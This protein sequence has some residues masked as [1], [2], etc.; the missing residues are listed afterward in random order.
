VGY[1]LDLTQR[2]DS[3]GRTS[4]NSSI[5]AN[6]K[7]DSYVLGSNELLFQTVAEPEEGAAVKSK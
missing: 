2:V 3:G 7:K 1:L 4:A 5:N 6:L